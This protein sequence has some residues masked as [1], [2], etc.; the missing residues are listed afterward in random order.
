MTSKKI[1]NKIF[2]TIKKHVPLSC[3]DAIIIKGNEFFLVKRNIPPYKNKWCLPGGIIKRGQKILDR[4]EQVG[5]EEL[6]TK[7]K[8]IK[9]TG[10]YE[11]MY[12]DR[13]DITHC[14][15]VKPKGTDMILNYQASTGKFF[16]KIPHNIAPF[17]IKMLK[18][19]GFH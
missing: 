3:V 17:H 1:P 10:F 12:K 5:N 8:I 16:K 7:F 9:S 18:D 15:I 13:H 14:F 11:K 6:G 2:N 4:L 19:A